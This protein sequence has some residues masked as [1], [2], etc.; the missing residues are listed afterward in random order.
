[1]Q[2]SPASKWVRVLFAVLCW[3]LAPLP[4]PAAD[5]EGRF[6]IEGV[7]IQTCKQFLEARAAGSETYERFSGWLEGYLTAA[8]RYAAGAYDIP[9]WEATEGLAVILQTK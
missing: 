4:A 6:A 1:M 8:N 3:A 9:P 7:G 5:A 2:L